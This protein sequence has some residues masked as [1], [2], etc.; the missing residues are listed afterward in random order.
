MQQKSLGNLAEQIAM[1]LGER[2]I[3]GELAGGTPIR[4]QAVTTDLQV[5]RGSVREALLI[6]QRQQLVDIFPR[7]GAQVKL[8]TADHVTAMYE[9]SM[10]LY[11]QLGTLT[12]LRWQ[13]ES[14]LMAFVDVRR[15]LEHSMQQKNLRG[16]VEY[17]FAILRTAGPIAG[18][19]FLMQAIENLIPAISRAY[20]IALERRRDEMGTFAR[21]FDRLLMAVR[22]RDTALLEEVV[23]EY[24]QHNCELVLASLAEG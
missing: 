1:Q 24:S 18:N 15:Q 9:F 3:C 10:S 17:S 13:S 23:K 21:K 6:L 22:E 14:Q 20:H 2:I 4:E 11:T 12:A 5:S 16:F 8:L 7:R 19:P